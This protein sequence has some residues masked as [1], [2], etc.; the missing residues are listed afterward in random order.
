MKCSRL[1]LLAMMVAVWGSLVSDA[2]AL[3]LLLV[4]ANNGY[5]T[6]EE[7]A[8]RSTFQSWGYT[9][10]TVWSGDYQSNINSAASSADVAYVSEETD[11]ATLG[12]KLRLVTIGVVNEENFLDDDFGFSDSPGTERSAT[13]IYLVSSSSYYT[14]TSNNQPLTEM[15]GNLAPGLNVWA[16]TSSSGK[17]TT[18]T[19]EAGGAL[20]NTISGNSTAAGR[21]VRLP[22]AGDAFSWSYLNSNGKTLVQQAIEWAAQTGSL[23]LHWKLDEGSGT[24]INDSSGNSH[25]ASFQNGTPTWTT[26]PRDGALDFNGSSYARSNSYFSP[27]STGSV[28]F[29][30]KRDTAVNSRE[31]PF[32]VS[33]TWEARLE[34]TG[35]LTFDIDGNASS[36]GFETSVPVDNIGQWYHIVAIFNA[37]NDTYKVYIDGQLDKSGSASL[38]GQSSNYLSLGTR[39]G[40]SEHFDGTI[41]DFRVYNYELTEKEIAEIYGLVGHW[42]FDEGY[43]STANDSTAYQND[44]TISGA[45]WSSDCSGNTVL[46]FDGASD[47]ATTGTTVDPPEKGTIAFWFQSEDPSSTLRRLWGI[48]DDFEMRQEAT[49]VVY[50]DVSSDSFSGGFYTNEGLSDSAKWYHMVATYDTTDDTYAIYI[51]GELHKS[52]V[53]ANDM[54][55]QSAGILSF[56]TRTG[57]SQYWKGS[58]RDFRIYNR[59]I[60][61]E[62]IVELAG[63]IAHYQ[64]DETSGSVAYDASLAGNDAYYYGSPTLGVSSPNSSE[65]GTAV[66]LNGTSQ[67]VS[68]SG[69]LLNNLT[70]FTI[71]GWV[72]LDTL[73]YNQSFFGQNDVIEFGINGA[74]N[75]VHLWTSGG[76]YLYQAGVFSTGRWTHVAAV[77]D[78]TKVAVY[79]DGVEVQSYS[80]TVYSSYGSS[81]YDFKIGEGV[82]AP[83]GDNLHGSVDDVRI[84]RRALCPA[85][86]EALS[87]AG[88][89]TGVRVLSW[90]EVQ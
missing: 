43:G 56:G 35:I 77:G 70:Q 69:S 3:K 17:V 74:T 16:R 40:A 75:Q 23:Y 8:R 65:F 62:E 9:V 10:T 5:L 22:I 60:L 51:D 63:V 53:S 66:Y 26:G 34:T 38:S 2:F 37:T 39:T 49:G 41:D 48:E 44:A 30:M 68:T 61:P 46:H 54:T 58:L 89:V 13:Q 55:K 24:T 78:G 85:E 45:N 18:A 90:V 27:P 81:S 19:I 42:K 59:E 32:G 79:I 6:S 28:A 67:S 64:L 73:D 80:K 7:S 31:R 83:S 82:F 11:S 76:G 84:Y 1:V 36:G 21:R 50:C 88:V 14:I 72:K 12:T 4:T 57:S 29:W 25:T 52:G 47:V 86:I 20:A 33:D 15:Q 87:T 71:A